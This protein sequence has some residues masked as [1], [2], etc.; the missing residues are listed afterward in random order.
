VKV[1]DDGSTSFHPEGM[2]PAGWD[3]NLAEIRATTP[4]SKLGMALTSLVYKLGGVALR[5]S[6]GVYW[7]PRDAMP[8]WRS[9]ARAVVRASGGRNVVYVIKHRMDEGAMRAVRDAVVEDVGREVEGIY[10]QVVSGGLGEK[11]LRKRV[12]RAACLAKQVE[13]YERYIHSSLDSLRGSLA[14]LETA[15]VSGRFQAVGSA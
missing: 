9:M 10:E 1:A 13:N 11:A 7:L 3:A 5:K 4:A 8:T 14:K 12:E 15:L 2:K 6:G